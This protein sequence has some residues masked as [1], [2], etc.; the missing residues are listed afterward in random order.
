MKMKIFIAWLRKKGGRADNSKKE[1]K[2]PNELQDNRSVRLPE[3]MG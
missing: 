3:V 2:S 1:K